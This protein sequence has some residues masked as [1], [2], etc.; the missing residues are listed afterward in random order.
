M[1]RPDINFNHEWH[2]AINTYN[3]H[4]YEGERQRFMYEAKT[5]ASE[6]PRMVLV[7]RQEREG[8]MDK[9]HKQCSMSPEVPVQDNHLTCCLGVECRKCPHLLALEKSALTP[10]QQDEAKAWTC[11]AHIVSKGGDLMNEG[12]LLTTGDRM[13]WDNVYE[14]L[15]SGSTDDS[16]AGK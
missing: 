11:A 5:M 15:S 6:V 13:F 7:L 14:S 12:Y 8:K 16:H 9:L 1:K 2:V 10:E 3:D 4:G